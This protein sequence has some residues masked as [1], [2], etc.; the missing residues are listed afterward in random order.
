MMR[1]L[2]GFAWL[3]AAAGGIAVTAGLAA[4]PALA[5]PA[6]WARPLATTWLVTPGGSFS[7]SGS[8]QV[9]DATT[10]TIARCTSIKMSG[11]LE[12]GSGLSGAG[13]GTITTASFTGCTIATVA[14]TVATNGLPWKLNATSYS[15]AKGVTTGTISGIDLVAS[16]PGCSATL[17][18]TAAGANDG[19]T[20]ITYTNSTA[21]IKL[22]GTGGNLHSYAVSGCFGLVN[23]G[24]VQQASG[25]G[26]VAPAQVIANKPD[27]AITIPVKVG[28]RGTE[29]F[30][31]FPGTGPF[32]WGNFNWNNPPG[33]PGTPAVKPGSPV[34]GDLQ[35]IPPAGG[36]PNKPGTYKL[37]GSYTDSANPKVTRTVEITLE[38]KKN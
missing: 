27:V 17:D 10:G 30:T 34:N 24:D 33:P 21:K 5:G 2:S 7:F 8:G 37:V 18:G 20:K 13:L 36:W 15:S 19:V 9:K 31:N 32:T 1:K 6:A 12:S 35:I 16:A 14:I 22:L 38:L 23:N 3:A 26:T 29:Q 28:G 11:T 4:P 25:S